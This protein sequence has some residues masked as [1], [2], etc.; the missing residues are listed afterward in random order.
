MEL[1]DPNFFRL[2]YLCLNGNGPMINQS[3]II[4]RKISKPKNI[5]RVKSSTASISKKVITPKYRKI[6]NSRSLL[7]ERNKNNIKNTLS[8]TKSNNKKLFNN[9]NLYQ[10]YYTENARINPIFNYPISLS[11]TTP[12]NFQNKQKNFKLNLY[13]DIMFK[14]NNNSKVHSRKV[15]E[16]NYFH[17][18]ISSGNIL[19]NNYVPLTEGKYNYLNNNSTHFHT[20]FFFKFDNGTN[21]SKNTIK[22][23]S[24]RLTPSK[25]RSKHFKHFYDTNKNSVY[26]KYFSQNES[27]INSSNNLNMQNSVNKFFNEE[28]KESFFRNKNN[29]YKLSSKSNKSNTLM[30]NPSFP[31]FKSD[32]SKI[33]KN[34][35]NLK[36][37]INSLKKEYNSQNKIKMK[38]NNSKKFK[39][40]GVY[41]EK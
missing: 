11:P 8:R 2:N 25:K 10:S 41:N 1:N 40:D 32:F 15:T 38:N 13:N 18:N 16:A 27:N 5:Q 22:G 35:K 21:I 12:V 3:V 7:K 23:S 20:H 34:K 31:S 37:I 28:E 6:D 29:S 14:S 30:E 24:Y 9:N 4:E 36:L 19:N 39:K 17:S 26:N 33:I